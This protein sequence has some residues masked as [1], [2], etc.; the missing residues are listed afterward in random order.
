MTDA[1]QT[2]GALPDGVAFT[3]HI[4]IRHSVKEG[5]NVLVLEQLNRNVAGLVVENSRVHRAFPVAHGSP[6]FEDL[7]PGDFVEWPKN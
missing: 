1:G 7:T 3:E 5:L 4:P 6:L 2:I